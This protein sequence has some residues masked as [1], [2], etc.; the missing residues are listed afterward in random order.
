MQGKGCSLPDSL[1]TNCATID[2]SLPKIEQ[3]SDALKKSVAEWCENLI[4]GLL[5]PEI[6]LDSTKAVSV[7][8]A[9]QSFFKMHQEFAVEAP[10]SPMTYYSA[11]CQDTVLFNDGKHLTLEITGYIY[12]GGAHGM[13]VADV[14]TFDIITGKKLNW[15]DL[16]T[17]KAALKA[18]AERKF[19]AERADI[20]QPTDG[21]E[22][23]Q[24]DDVFVFDLPSNYGQTQEG[25]YC[26]YQPYEV[27]PYA[28]GSTTFT[29]SFAEIGALL[30]QTF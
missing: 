23:F 3:G 22:P 4:T 8:Q 20:F 24:F 29:I 1:R 14:S 18:I 25:I 12:T 7:E 10:D 21:S 6:D 2:F 5:M 26:H 11:E 9:A 28:I 17:D 16:V 19:R 13:P 27:G 30:K 15:D